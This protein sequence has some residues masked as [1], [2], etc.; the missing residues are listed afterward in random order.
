LAWGRIVCPNWGTTYLFI[1]IA[2]RCAAV[3]A[4]ASGISSAASC[5]RGCRRTRWRLPDRPVAAVAV[6]GFFMLGFGKSWGLQPR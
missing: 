5:C 4:A 6:I 3:P 2:R 1:K